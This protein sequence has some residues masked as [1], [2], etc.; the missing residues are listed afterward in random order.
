MHISLCMCYISLS[1]FLTEHG[2]LTE[3]DGDKCSYWLSF[4]FFS[5][6]FK[7]DHTYALKQA[8]VTESHIDDP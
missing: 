8:R 4:F 7:L 2:Y 5:F 6:F 3:F 1:L